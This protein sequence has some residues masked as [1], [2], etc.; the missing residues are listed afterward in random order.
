MS[1][2]FGDASYWIAQIDPDDEFHR[3]SQECAALIALENRRVVTTQLVLNE[4]LNPRSGTTARQRRAT[5]ELVDRI[6]RDTQVDIVPQSPE[7]FA[8]ALNMLR[9]AVDDKEWSITDCA[10]FLTMRQF[11]IQESLTGDRHFAQ[12]GFTVMLNRART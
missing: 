11:S 3:Q 6:G 7:Q 1:D 12:A 9:T 4:V 8:E 10:S 5:I 2:Y